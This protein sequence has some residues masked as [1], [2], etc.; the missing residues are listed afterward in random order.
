M[1][2]ALVARVL[3]CCIELCFFPHRHRIVHSSE[4]IVAARYE[5]QSRARWIA[6][7]AGRLRS[8]LV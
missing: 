4:A 2:V 8:D 5:N 1:R 3:L 7:E 6:S